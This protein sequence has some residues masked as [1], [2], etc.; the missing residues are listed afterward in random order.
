M[1]SRRRFWESDRKNDM[2]R[3]EVEDVESEALAVGA[4]W[5]LLDDVDLA[6]L[7]AP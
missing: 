6:V 2:K 7:S 3:E 4:E 5:M 1:W